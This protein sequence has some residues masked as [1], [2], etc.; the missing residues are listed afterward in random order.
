MS[1]HYLTTESTTIKAICDA[2]EDFFRIPGDGHDLLVD[3]LGK[4]V[5]GKEI[6]IG[7]GDVKDDDDMQLVVSAL[8]IPLIELGVERSSIFI[9]SSS[10]PKDLTLRIHGVDWAITLSKTDLTKRTTKVTNK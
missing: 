7:M 3:I 5:G 1:V 2:I 10:E 6:T 9:S 4:D 8:V